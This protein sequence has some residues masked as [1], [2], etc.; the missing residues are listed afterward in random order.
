MDFICIIGNYQF[1]PEI[2]KAGDFKLKWLI[3]IIA[4]STASLGLH[5]CT[6]TIEGYVIHKLEELI[7]KINSGSIIIAKIIH[8]PMNWAKLPV[9]LNPVY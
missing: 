2:N 6:V 1:N 8:P 4:F 9:K 3:L 5:R 7:K